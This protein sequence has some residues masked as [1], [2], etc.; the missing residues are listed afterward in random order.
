MTRI[1]EVVFI[2]DDSSSMEGARWS[3]TRDALATIVEKAFELK[4]DTVSLRF[5]NN[6]RHVRGFQ[7]KETLR[8]L[9]NTMRPRGLTPLGRALKAVFQEHLNRIDAAVGMGQEEYSKIP[10]LDIIV[11]TDGV[12][13][14]KGEDEPAKVIAKAV[15]RLNDIHYHPNTMNVQIVQIANERD[16]KKAFES[17][18]LGDNRMIVGTVPYKGIL[19][20]EKLQKIL[21]GGLHPNTRSQLR[22]A[23]LANN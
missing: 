11:L 6:E 23:T 4:V 8:S 2:V 17:L 9:F 15:K 18:V 7:G 5:L 21:L 10:P 20:P 14:D 1:F 13:T 12:P 16:A 3:E 19:D 22:V